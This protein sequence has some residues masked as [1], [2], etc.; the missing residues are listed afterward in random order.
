L[1]KLDCIGIYPAF[2][3]TARTIRLEFSLPKIVQYCLGHNRASRIAG[4]EE[5]HIE[6]PARHQQSRDLI[7]TASLYDTTH[8]GS[9]TTDRRGL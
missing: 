9:M 5:K 8:D 1:Q 7:V 6:W 4:A 3:L 2:G